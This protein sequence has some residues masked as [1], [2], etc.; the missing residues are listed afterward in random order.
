MVEE[1]ARELLACIHSALDVGA[2]AQVA[3]LHADDSATAPHL[4]VLPIDD[5]EECA[6]EL[7]RDAL[8]Q[9]TSGNHD[10]RY[11]LCASGCGK[12]QM[13]RAMQDRLAPR[14]GQPPRSM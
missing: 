9:V 5:L 10:A 14:R 1:G 7:N 8:L 12:T 11:P 13:C 2:S 3:Q 6:L 4:D